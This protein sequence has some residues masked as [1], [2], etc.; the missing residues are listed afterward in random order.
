MP[1]TF[2]LNL[3]FKPSDSLNIAE[4]LPQPLSSF[5]LSY[6]YLSLKQTT[7]PKPAPVIT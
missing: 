2:L 5:A 7:P 4:D 3:N 1:S 6:F